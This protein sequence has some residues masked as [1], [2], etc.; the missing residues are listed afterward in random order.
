MQQKYKISKENKSY[1]GNIPYNKN[2]TDKINAKLEEM[3]ENMTHSYTH[4][5]IAEYCLM[6]KQA[7]YQIELKAKRKMRLGLWDVYKEWEKS[8]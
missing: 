6:S 3:V 7:V 2:R 5:E 8:K 1:A 4:S